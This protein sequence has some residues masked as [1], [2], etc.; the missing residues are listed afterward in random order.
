MATLLALRE[1]AADSLRRAQLRLV[2]SFLR[3]HQPLSS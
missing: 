3:V 2:T 1:A